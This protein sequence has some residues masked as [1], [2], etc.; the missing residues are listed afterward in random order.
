MRAPMSRPHP[1][2]DLHRQAVVAVIDSAEFE[3]A[4]NDP[5]VRSFLK[6]ADAY[7]TELERQ[8]RNR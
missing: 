3:A 4:E 6:E 5:R 1:S 2:S 7:L 8:G